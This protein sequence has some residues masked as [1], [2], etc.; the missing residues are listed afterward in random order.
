MTCA[1]RIGLSR[2]ACHKELSVRCEHSLDFLWGV[3]MA[4]G[5]GIFQ[6]FVFRKAID[7]HVLVIRVVQCS[8]LVGYGYTAEICNLIPVT[9]GACLVTC[10]ALARS[11]AATAKKSKSLLVFLRKKSNKF[12]EHCL[13]NIANLCALSKGILL[14]ST[15]CWIIVYRID[16]EVPRILASSAY[17]KVQ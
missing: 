9:P 6:Y 2:P 14:A 12:F 10:L 5:A 8:A 4:H 13:C 17:I 7:S 16:L 1:A 15:T 11:L 3:R